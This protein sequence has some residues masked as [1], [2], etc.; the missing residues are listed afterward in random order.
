MCYQLLLSSAS[1]STSTAA[2]KNTSSLLESKTEETCAGLQTSYINNLRSIP[3]VENIVT[4]VRYIQTMR[5]EV[6]LSDHYRKDLRT[7]SYGKKT[8]TE[9]DSII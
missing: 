3:T 9:Q 4:I 8:L 7:F 2:T 5:S 1:S 6:N